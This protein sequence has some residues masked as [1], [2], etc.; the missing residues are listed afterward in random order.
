VGTAANA[1]LDACPEDAKY[2]MFLDA[3]D[4]MAAGAVQKLTATAE[5]TG[6]DVVVGDW[7]RYEVDTGKVV[8]AYDAQH[9]DPLPRDE[10]FAPEDHPS[11][12][13]MSP[14]PWR[15]LYRRCVWNTRL[16]ERREV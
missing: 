14:V 5:A 3:D 11:V 4:A 12:M 1:G 10:L 6:A 9:T 8:E 15:K 13:R 2:V 16:D 7:V